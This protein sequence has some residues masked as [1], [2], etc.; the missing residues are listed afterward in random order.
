MRKSRTCFLTQ[1]EI[2]AFKDLNKIVQY[3]LVIFNSVIWLHILK[4][5]FDLK[6]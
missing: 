1:L 5:I 2:K 4:T 3:L 6:Y